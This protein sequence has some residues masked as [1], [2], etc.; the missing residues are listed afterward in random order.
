MSSYEDEKRA[1]AEIDRAFGFE[2]D[3]VENVIQ[4]RVNLEVHQTW[5]HLSAQ[6]FQTPYAELERIIAAADPESR[7]NTW[8]DVGAAYGRLGIVL[9][10]TRPN[11]RFIG[12]E[13]VPERVIEGR[14]IFS[15][16]GMDPNLLRCED[17]VHSP[18]PAAEVYFIY[19][20]GRREAIDGVLEKLRTQAAASPITVIGRGRSI[21]DAIE[22]DQP[23][24]SSVRPPQHFPHFSVYF[25]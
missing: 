24:L 5:S 13:V 2:I 22:R 16:L 23:W 1:S 3:R 20:F 6:V 11:A 12:L 8:V 18:L 21:R 15:S 17:V 10:R 4:Q 9:H 14:R 7:V 19:D 25:S